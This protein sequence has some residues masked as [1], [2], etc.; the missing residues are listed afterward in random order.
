MAEISEK[1]F[2]R[3]SNSLTKHFGGYEDIAFV[4]NYSALE[5]VFERRINFG[6]FYL[7][8]MLNF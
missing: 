8:T 6:S 5:K 7:F 3:H 4:F 2:P 1:A